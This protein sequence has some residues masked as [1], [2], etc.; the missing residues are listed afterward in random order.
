[1][2]V[3]IISWEKQVRFMPQLW[4]QKLTRLPATLLEQ[5]NICWVEWVDGTDILISS[6][7]IYKSELY[8]TGCLIFR[9]EKYFVMIRSF[10]WCWN[11]SSVVRMQAEA[12]M[13]TSLRVRSVSLTIKIYGCHSEEGNIP[14]ITQY[15]GN[16]I[17]WWRDLSGSTFK[18]FILHQLQGRAFTSSQSHQRES[19]IP[20]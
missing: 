8:T 7:F 3:S 1:M 17:H 16:W 6:I 5:G 2:I 15:W 9:W 4:W 20:A 13:M 10:N 12:V 14:H 18:Q 19:A 11:L